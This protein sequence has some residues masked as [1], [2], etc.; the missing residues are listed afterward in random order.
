MPTGAK[1]NG[2]MGRPKPNGAVRVILN[3]SAP[4]GSSVNSG[5]DEE[6]FPAVMSSTAKWVAVL[7]RVGRNFLM[8]KANWSDVYKHI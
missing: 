1:I 4:E 8:T 6:E 3:M 2:I 5:I 7:N